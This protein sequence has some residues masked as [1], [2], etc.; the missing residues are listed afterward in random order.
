MGTGKDLELEFKDVTNGSNKA[1]FLN[2]SCKFEGS[3]HF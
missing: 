2:Y 1:G 3:V